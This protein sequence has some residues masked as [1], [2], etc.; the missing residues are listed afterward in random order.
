MRI[1]LHTHSS[2]SDGTDRPTD[3]VA[4]AASAGLDVVALTDHDTIDGWSE[5]IAAGTRTGIEVIPG[6]EISTEWHGAGV[7]LLA[8][9]VD[10]E[11]RLLATELARVRADRRHRLETIVGRLAR[12]GMPLAVEEIL[13]VAGPAV[14]VGRPHVADAMIARGYVRDREEAFT[15]WLGAGRGGHVPKYAPG[16]A[17]A[18]AMVRAAGG[19][20]V[21]AHPWGR[22]SRWCLDEAAVTALSRAGLDGIEVD[23]ED[24][25]ASDREALREL[26]ADLD[27]VVTGSSDYHGAGKTGHGLGINTTAPDQWERLKSTADK[28]AE[29]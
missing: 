9:L 4:Q 18:I 14:A 1:D 29:A 7:H 24:H 25:D 20:T 12:Q 19:V 22:E 5:A 23:H 3:L 17:E 10:P 27:L 6:I 21:L 26:A 15:Q 16:T 28:R 8:Y 13:A 2:V 11:D